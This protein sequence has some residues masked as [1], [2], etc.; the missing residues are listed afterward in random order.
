M[1]KE[2]HFPSLCFSTPD[3]PTRVPDVSIWESVPQTGLA[4]HP[5]S[6]PPSWFNGTAIH[7]F[8]PETGATLE[9]SSHVP[10]IWAA[11]RPFYLLYAFLI[12]LSL[13]SPTSEALIQPFVIGH[14]MSVYFLYWSCLVFPPHSNCEPVTGL[15]LQLKCKSDQLTPL[16]H[17]KGRR[18]SICDAHLCGL[19][20]IGIPSLLKGVKGGE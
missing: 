18:W 10:H 20:L 12:N 11:P 7:P 3:L 5:R 6:T 4:F 15:I 16:Y 8:M 1:G 2:N 19:H 17:F 14:R 13:W 9:S